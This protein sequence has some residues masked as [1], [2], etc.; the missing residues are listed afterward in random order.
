MTDTPTK[1]EAVRLSD[2]DLTELE[3]LYR[4]ATEAPL[5]TLNADQTWIYIPHGLGGDDH[6]GICE[7]DY[8]DD[9]GRAD[10]RLIA[11]AVSALPALIGMARRVRELETKL[12][13]YDRLWIEHDW[14]RMQAFSRAHG[15]EPGENIITITL[16][17][18][19]KAE[20]ERDHYKRHDER[21]ANLLGTTDGGQYVN[22]TLARIEDL[23]KERDAL[24]KQ[25]E[26]LT[27][28]VRVLS[29]EHKAKLESAAAVIDTVEEVINRLDGGEASLE[30]IV[31][32]TLVAIDW[33]S[34]SERRAALSPTEGGDHKP[35]V[36][37]LSAAV[38]RIEGLDPKEPRDA[39]FGDPN[40]TR[41]ADAVHCVLVTY[42]IVKYP[43]S[44]EGG[45]NVS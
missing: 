6:Y 30:D 2:A 7:A 20:A 15:G 9:D 4:E 38:C 45:D 28:N 33:W 42:G 36:Q 23:L 1:G 35:L 26:A 43:A 37:A 39:E 13:R 14:E 16:D 12:A 41:Y 19:E 27:T 31:F 22:D 3:R 32:E 8:T 17:A 34:L 10:M 5:W 21:I 11:A 18:A 44:T 24:K 25:V 29:R 40:W